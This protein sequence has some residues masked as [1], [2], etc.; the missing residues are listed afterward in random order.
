MRS[1]D[2]IET[3]GVNAHFER[4]QNGNAIWS[5]QRVGLRQKLL[6]SGIGNIRAAQAGNLATGSAYMRYQQSL[7]GVKINLRTDWN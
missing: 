7:N 4:L 1:S 5:K 2:F 3:I 6:E